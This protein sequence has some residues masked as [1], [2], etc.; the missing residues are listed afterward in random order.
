MNTRK[1]ALIA[2]LLLLVTLA[3][4]LPAYAQETTPEPT[5]ETTADAI[6]PVGI[7]VTTEPNTDGEVDAAIDT[8]II[9]V[10]EQATVEATAEV[11][12]AGS[13][14]TVE[15]QPVAGVAE[16]HSD[17]TLRGA[18]LLVLLVGLAAV[19]TIGFITYARQ[20]TSPE[21]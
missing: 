12:G 7:D 16:T 4:M 2:S 3:L 17:D 13:T 9:E 10:T 1:L 20:S 14:T 6:A 15:E 21:K 18:S 11:A 5:A 8:T 19:G